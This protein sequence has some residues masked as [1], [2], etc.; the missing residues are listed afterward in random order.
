MTKLAFRTYVIILFSALILTSCHNVKIGDGDIIETQNFT[1]ST[2]TLHFSEV[3]VNTDCSV[4]LTQGNLTLIRVSGYQNLVSDIKTDIGN[5][6]LIISLTEGVVH[7]NSNIQVDITTPQY[8]KI[9]LN[10]S[11][12]IYS[13]DSIIGNKIEVVNNGSGIISLHGDMSL[14]DSYSAGSGVTRLCALQAD[15]VNA[16]MF[17]SGILSTLPLNRLNAQIPGSGQIQYIGS[18]SI[19]FSIT[20]SGSISQIL[21]C[22]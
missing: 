6:Q 1:D 9:S 21:G 7:N 13:I 12:S 17:G 14:V 18:P 22:Y 5:N 3:I 15:T 10:S 2:S 8:T 4:Y 20:G 11:A 16:F 19:S